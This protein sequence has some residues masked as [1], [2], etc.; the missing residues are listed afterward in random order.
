MTSATDELRRL[1]VERG[2]K[3]EDMSI[4]PYA[5]TSWR[6]PDGEPCTAL[7]GADDIPDGKLSAQALLTP[8]QAVEATLGREPDDAAMVKLHEQMNTALLEYERAQGIEMRDGDAAVTVPF[9]AKMHEL[10]EE[11]VTLG[12]GT[13]HAIVSDN[14]TESEGTGDA[15]ADCSECGHLLFV[16]TDP[17]S[18]P[19]H[20]CPNC[21][22][23]VV[24]DG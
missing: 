12:R 1:L 18:K 2:V 10:L 23:K 16:L 24:D 6:D 21:G 14:L 20:Y 13:C 5:C 22:R 19:P 3:W 17:S 9:V 11:A 15:W 4:R 8:E 7:E